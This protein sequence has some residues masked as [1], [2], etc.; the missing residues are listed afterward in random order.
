M[1]RHAAAGAV[2]LVLVGV[3]TGLVTTKPNPGL[4]VSLILLGVVSAVL[5]VMQQ[6]SSQPQLAAA[7]LGNVGLYA[8]F[9][10]D[11]Y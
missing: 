5:A 6:R 11:P 2:V 10:N 7:G 9:G 8:P 3:V 1:T 4:V